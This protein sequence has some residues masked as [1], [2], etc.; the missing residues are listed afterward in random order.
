MRTQKRRRK[1]RERARKLKALGFKLLIVLLTALFIAAIAL[2]VTVIWFRPGFSNDDVSFFWKNEQ[3]KVTWP[4]VTEGYKCQVFIY[5][6]DKKAY[7]LVD[8]LEENEFILNN[9]KEGSPLKIKLQTIGTKEDIF[10]NIRE[11]KGDRAELDI[12]P[13]S[14]NS[15]VIHEFPD[16]ENLQMTL[17]WDTDETEFY[18]VFIMD[19]A[20][21]WVYQTKTSEGWYNLDFANKM[22]LPD[23]EKPLKISVRACYPQKDGTF[24]SELSETVLIER[25]ELLPDYVEIDWE[26][27][28]NNMY[29]IFWEESQG[30]LYE[31]QQW[32]YD[33]AVW[34]KISVVNWNEPL[35]YEIGR[36]PSS[37]NSRYRVIT[38][39]EDTEEEKRL[40]VAEPGIVNFWSD[41]SPL[42]C[43]VWPIQDIEMYQDSGSNE[44]TGKIPAAEPLC[45]LGEENGMFQVMY[46]D[47]YGYIDSDYCL[48]NLPEYLGDLCKYNITNSYSSVFRVHEYD[49][50]HMTEEIIPGYENIHLKTDE[51]LVPFLY[52]CSQ[53]LRLAAENCIADGYNLVI[54]DAFRPNEATRAMYDTA[55]LVLD[56][57]VPEIILPDPEEDAQGTAETA[58]EETSPENG[59]ESEISAEA[60]LPAGE[61]VSDNSLVFSNRYDALIP[62]ALANLTKMTPEELALI[63]LT[64]ETVATVSGCSAESLIYLKNMS[65]ETWS[66]I[67][68]GVFDF[69][70]E[71]LLYTQQMLMAQNAALLNQENPGEESVDQSVSENSMDILEAFQFP[72]IR[73]DTS[74]MGIFI[75]VK[76]AGLE[77]LPLK[78][79]LIWQS[80]PEDQFIA[81]K[82]YLEAAVQTYYH[83]MT[84]DRYRLGSFLAQV[85][86]THNRG[87]ALDL[88]IEKAETGEELPM[89]TSIHDLSWYSALPYNNENAALLADYMLDAGFHDLSS[90]W[91]HFQDDETR[92][93]LGLNAFLTEGLSI[94]G[95]KKNDIGWYYQLSD[96]SYYKNISVEIDGKTYNFNEDGYSNR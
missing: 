17:K 11:V 4:A 79:L 22:E 31:V 40:E 44:S 47:Q 63:G 2:F 87:I 45:V 73:I 96:G 46:Q 28:A 75:D 33:A 60:I 83:V 35:V 61:S 39:N 81:F 95:W 68:A 80:L 62:E 72:V 94:E 15:P 91:W 55:L 41:L 88:T 27:S 16:L 13:V 53:K 14:V 3:L 10:G 71:K 36:I 18:E 25:A 59:G 74:L 86:S 30:E 69:E 24:Y 1:A 89:Q 77:N 21:E 54:Y 37:R 42:Y 56:Y 34:E 26:K 19:E 32:N 64:P 52:P 7:R 23:R 90:E 84:D 65:Y 6:D 48:I 78:D 93:S 58:E 20:Q 92:N 76:G 43:T 66:L 67:Q 57:P 29:R 51:Y 49:I 85:T 70:A 50:P 82:S 38:Y 8:E 12:I 9:I 5:D